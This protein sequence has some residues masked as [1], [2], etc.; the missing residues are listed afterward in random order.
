MSQLSESTHKVLCDTLNRLLDEQG[1]SLLKQPL[2]LEGWLRDLHPELRAAVSVVMECLH[3]NLCYSEG[4]VSDVSSKLSKQSGV[5]PNW[6][7]F[8]IRVW[9]AT[10]RGRGVSTLI[11][12]QANNTQ[13]VEQVL[14]IYRTPADLEKI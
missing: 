6:A 7:D 8:G 12:Q 11:T 2:R 14:S 13:T 5:S 3:T 10:L 4:S 1:T 9:R